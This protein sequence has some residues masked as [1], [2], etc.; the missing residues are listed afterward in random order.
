M[1]AKAGEANRT[2]PASQCRRF[3]AARPAP[4]PNPPPTANVALRATR[5]ASQNF[6]PSGAKQI[7]II[8]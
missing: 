6:A 1:P 2:H 7:S 3:A 8:L 5:P 4:T